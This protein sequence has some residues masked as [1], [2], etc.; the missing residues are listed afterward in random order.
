MKKRKILSLPREEKRTQNYKQRRFLD[1]A[2]PAA[3]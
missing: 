3:Y 2:L 1:P